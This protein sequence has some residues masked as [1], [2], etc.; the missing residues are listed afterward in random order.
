MARQA[1][2]N[3]T[4]VLTQ[5]TIPYTH[6]EQK[7]IGN[8]SWGRCVAKA[9]HISFLSAC[10]PQALLSRHSSKLYTYVFFCPKL[11]GFCNLSHQLGISAAELLLETGFVIFVAFCALFCTNTSDCCVWQSQEI[12][13][14]VSEIPNDMPLSCSWLFELYCCTMTGWSVRLV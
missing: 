13:S 11:T 2:A 6:G 4:A 5:T 7:I 1:H 8:H 10:Q 9:H 3:R 14:A 12:L